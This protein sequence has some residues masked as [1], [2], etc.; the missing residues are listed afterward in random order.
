MA[1]RGMLIK[2]DRGLD[3][4]IGGAPRGGIQSPPR[5]DS[6]A[7]LGSVFPNLRP[8]LAVAEGD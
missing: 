4:P 3:I 7:V 1:S 5:V 6:V 2:L 8:A